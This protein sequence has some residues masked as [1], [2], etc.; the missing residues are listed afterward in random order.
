MPA[1]FRRP[2]ETDPPLSQHQFGA[3]LGGPIARDRT[4]FF[5]SYEGQRVERSLTQ[6]F[7]VPPAALRSGDFSGLPALCDPVTRVDGGGCATFAGNHIPHVPAGSGRRRSSR[8]GA[9]ANQHRIGAEPPGCWTSSEPHGSVERASRPPVVAGRHLYS[10]FTSYN[11]RDEQPSHYLAQRNAGPG[12]DGPSP[13][14]AGISR[15]ATRIPS[16]R[17]G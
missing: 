2:H 1:I 10:R 4:F 12:L 9:A 13:R 6:T 7:T 16:A 17:T 8:P 3:N 5:F 11:I 14:G 15:L